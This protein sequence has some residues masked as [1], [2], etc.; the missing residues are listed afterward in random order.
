MRSLRPV[1]QLNAWPGGQPASCSA[2]RTVYSG[3][4]AGRQGA[5]VHGATELRYTRRVPLGCASLAVV[6]L[7][8]A[9]FNRP[10]WSRRLEQRGGPR[11]VF[12]CAC[13]CT[14]E[15]GTAGHI[16]PSCI[17]SVCALQLPVGASGERVRI[18]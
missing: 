15:P 6:A 8:E 17:L 16:G 18:L 2:G 13:V 9:V 7:E 11:A 5:C 12:V 10:E 4:R 14:R 1:G 3:K